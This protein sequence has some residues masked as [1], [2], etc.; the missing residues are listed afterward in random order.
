MDPHDIESTV[1]PS[2][3]GK[4]HNG[5]SGTKV[6]KVKQNR[7]SLGGTCCV[8]LSS[9]V[10]VSYSNDSIPTLGQH[11]LIQ[12]WTDCHEQVHESPHGKILPGDPILDDQQHAENVITHSATRL[13]ISQSPQDTHSSS[14]NVHLGPVSPNAFHHSRFNFHHPL[15]VHSNSSDGSVEEHSE[16][17]EHIWARPTTTTIRNIR[18][19]HVE[20]E[21]MKHSSLFSEF[22]PPNLHHSTQ[23]HAPF[24]N[25]S[26]ES[27][28]SSSITSMT[29]FSVTS[30]PS[31]DSPQTPF[32]D[33]LFGDRKREPHRKF[34]TRLRYV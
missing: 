20:M 21:H 34:I 2:D 1:I 27:S 17:S 4:E 31:I 10:H 15:Q 30:P 6:D 16:Q 24:S 11:S 13:D 18:K 9:P 3:P 28:S 32:D 7:T 26:N 23:L 12:R 8:R 33:L 19:S 29:S 5:Q 14:P 22:C 25:Q